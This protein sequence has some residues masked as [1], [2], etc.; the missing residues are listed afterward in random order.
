MQYLHELLL[1]FKRIPLNKHQCKYLLVIQTLHGQQKWMYENKVHRV[2]NRSVSIHQP[3]VR[4]IVRGKATTD[5]EFGAKIQVSI[6]NGMVFLKELSWDA[7]NEGTRLI[8]SIENYIRRIG[9]YLEK[10]FADKIYCNRENRSRLKALN[11]KMMAKPLARP[12]A[13]A[14]DIHLRP[15]ERWSNRRKI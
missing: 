6:M 7:F 2:D 11:I 15:E 5:V 3:H 13:K 1:C 9:N 4:P 14:V 10:V 8:E 12:S